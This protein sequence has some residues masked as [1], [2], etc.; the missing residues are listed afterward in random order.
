[1][2]SYIGTHKKSIEANISQLS[3]KGPINLECFKVLGDL[4]TRTCNTIISYFISFNSFQWEAYWYTPFEIRVIFKY[5]PLQ[6]QTLC[7][8]NIYF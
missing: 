1:M 3:M 4:S 8:G 6:I 2:E 5:K 7:R